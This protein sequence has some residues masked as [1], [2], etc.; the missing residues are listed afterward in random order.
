MADYDIIGKSNVRYDAIP[1][2]DGSMPYGED[3]IPAGALQC[4]VLFT[5]VP[6]GRLK[7]STLLKPKKFQA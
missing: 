2:A 1:K 4:G 5:P 6:V 3:A 7:S